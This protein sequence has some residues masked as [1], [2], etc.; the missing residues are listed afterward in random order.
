MIH[1]SRSNTSS[2]G[3]ADTQFP[4]LLQDLFYPAVEVSL[5]VLISG[6]CIQVL[7]N[8]G[9]PAVRLGTE[10]QLNLDEGLETGVEVGD[11]EVDQLGQF[12][13]QLLV[14]LLIGGPCDVHLLFGAGQFRD[15][16]VGL[17]GQLLDPGP[18]SVV[19][20]QFVTALLDA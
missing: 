12:A 11:A 5:C 19:V 9:H 10:A 6:V 8:L 3:S 4:Y 2:H 17:L 16:L 20:E 14:E 13:A 7:L 18:Q 15:I 1:S